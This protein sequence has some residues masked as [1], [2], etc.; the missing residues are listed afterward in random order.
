MTLAAASMVLTLFGS[1]DSDFPRKSNA[2][3]LSPMRKYSRPM[4]VSTS[5]LSG[6]NF[7]ASRQTATAD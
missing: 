6:L 2:L 1:L 5:A 4:V 7:K 3:K